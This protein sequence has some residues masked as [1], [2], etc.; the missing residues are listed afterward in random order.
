MIETLLFPVCNLRLVDRMQMSF[1]PSVLIICIAIR[2]SS[3]TN[4]LTS[5][6]PI[7]HNCYE[8]CLHRRSRQLIHNAESNFYATQAMKVFAHRSSSTLTSLQHRGRS[9]YYQ[10]CLRRKR[11]ADRWA[12]SIS[13]AVTI[14]PS[15]TQEKSHPSA[16]SSSM[17]SIV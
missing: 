15:A 7:S 4:V 13:I 5:L 17:P 10:H 12:T 6:I 14:R 16:A 11:V 3:P 9:S 2:S 8:W 1:K